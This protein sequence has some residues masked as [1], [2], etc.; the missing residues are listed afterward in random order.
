MR[1]ILVEKARRKQR[2]REIRG[3]E[4]LPLNE[5]LAGRRDPSEEVLIVD[6]ALEELERQLPEA[7]RLVKLRYFAGISLSDAA[8]I[9]G[10][11]R[12]TAYEHWSFA[13]AFLQSR[14]DDHSP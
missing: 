12:S 14:L 8:A 9:T 2:R 5:D 10:I 11:A 13:R 1:R 7:A 4:I 6:E 3:G